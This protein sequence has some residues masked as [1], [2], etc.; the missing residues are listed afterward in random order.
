[1]LVILPPS[2]TKRPGGEPGSR[3]RLS[4]L[5]FPVLT[6]QRRLTLS[7]V[8][9]LARDHDASIAALRLGPK[10]HGEV[11]KNRRITTSPTMPAV[12]RYTGVLYDALDAGTLPA[13]SRRYLGDQVVVHSAV[14][15]PIGAMDAIPDYRLSHDSR[16]PD[17]RLRAVWAEAARGAFAATDELVI[18]A[19]SEA[20]VTLGPAPEHAVFVRVVAET[21]DGARRALNHF[22]K[23]AKG[24]FVRALAQ[25]LARPSSVPE[26]IAWA[27]GRGIRMEPAPDAASELLLFA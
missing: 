19:R 4:D 18:D 10:Q 9:A 3:L 20:Y 26:L 16:L 6:P 2:E 7:A 5:R 27:T 24:A 1:M 12:D 21:P 25:D 22:N 23:R 11:A 13:Q 17:V 8:R 14:L 15:G